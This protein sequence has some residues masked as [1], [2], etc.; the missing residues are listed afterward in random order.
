MALAALSSRAERWEKQYSDVSD[1][2]TTQEMGLEGYTGIG[3][4]P[5]HCTHRRD[6]I[7][8]LTSLICLESALLQRYA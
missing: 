4:Y 6:P 7:K 3:Q 8:V 2:I 1:P 5:C